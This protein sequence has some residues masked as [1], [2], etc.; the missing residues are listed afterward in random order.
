MLLSIIAFIVAIVILV[1]IHEF[2]HFWVA[3]RCGIKVLQFSIGFGKPLWRWRGKKDQ[4]EYIVAAIPLG[5][6]VKM[7]D[8]RE[9]PVPVVERDRAFNRQSIGARAAVIAAGPLINLL[10]AVLVLALVSIWGETGMRPWIGQVSPNSLAAE[11]GLQADDVF[12]SVNGTET[13]TWN[14][15]LQALAIESVQGKALDVQVR[16]AQ[17]MLAWRTFEPLSDLVQQ[18]NLLD[19]LGLQPKQ[20]TLS[21]VIGQM[22]PEKPAELAGLQ[23]GDRILSANDTEVADWAALVALVRASPDKPLRLSVE[24]AGLQ[25]PLVLTPAEHTV[26]NQVIGQI[27]VLPEPLSPEVLEQFQV[28]YQLSPWQ[29]LTTAL[30]RTIDWSA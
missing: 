23:V 11:A 22:I 2:G 14:M 8:E 21:A 6:F 29:A 12:V 26:G 18:E 3:R 4:T 17:G 20:P 28:Y 27:G 25:V 30:V 10:F 15:T 19:Y 1:G 9:G 7:L 13:P 5:G 16:D 24:R